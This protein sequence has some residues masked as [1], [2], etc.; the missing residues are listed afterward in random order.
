MVEALQGL[1][2]Y[3]K[4]LIHAFAFSASAWAIMYRPFQGLK[5]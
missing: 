1:F 2:D 4:L 5:E 3:F